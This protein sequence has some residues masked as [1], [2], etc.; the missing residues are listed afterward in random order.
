VGLNG[1]SLTDELILPLRCPTLGI[2]LLSAD[3][4]FF[5]LLIGLLLLREERSA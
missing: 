1:C 5:L 2:N 4:C 3:S